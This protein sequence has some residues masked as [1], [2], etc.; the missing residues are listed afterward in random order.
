MYVFGNVPIKGKVSKRKCYVAP[1][2]AKQ[3]TKAEPNKKVK[4]NKNTNDKQQ[5]KAKN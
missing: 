2:Q 1:K 5:G 3:E 4:S